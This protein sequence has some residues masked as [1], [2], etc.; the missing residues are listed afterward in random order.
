[1]HLDA[2]SLSR[3]RFLQGTVATVACSAARGFAQPAASDDG[4][5]IDTNV[6]IGRWP[7]RRLTDDDPSKLV[8][9]LRSNRVGK[10]WAGNFDGL[11]H[12]DIHGANLRLS[13]ACRNAGQ[14]MLIPFGTVNPMLPDWEEDIRCCDEEL[15]MPGIRVYPAYH[16]YMLDDQCFVKLLKLAAARKLIVQLIAWMTDDRH[17]LLTPRVSQVDLSPLSDIVKPMRQTRLVLSNAVRTTRDKAVRGLSALPQ[18]YFGCARIANGRDLRTLVQQVSAERIVFE[19][20]APVSAMGVG[21]EML[22]QTMLA[23]EQ[24]W[25][26]CRETAQRLIKQSTDDNER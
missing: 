4:D 23:Y 11:F 18:V 22:K 6:Y 13:D 21:L 26:I 14:G 15:K 12:K 20:G 7:L 5:I 10:A 17:P 2:H 1:M 24:S 9:T 19:S 8:A 3:R 16:G 25:A